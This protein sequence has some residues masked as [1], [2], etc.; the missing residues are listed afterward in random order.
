MYP[1]EYLTI[2]NAWS[3]VFDKMRPMS[4]TTT[5]R[6]SIRLITNSDL[7]FLGSF[8]TDVLCWPFNG[9]RSSSKVA[10]QSVKWS[11]GFNQKSHAVEGLL[12]ASFGGNSAEKA[13]RKKTNADQSEVCQLGED[14]APGRWRIRK[15]YHHQADENIARAEWIQLRV[16]SVTIV[17]SQ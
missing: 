10:V 16:S 2:Y 7:I 14:F 15:D 6:K 12:P 5:N 4:S 1:P 13:A 8:H 11:G 17:L 9:W 3:P